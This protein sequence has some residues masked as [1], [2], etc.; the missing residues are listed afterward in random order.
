MTS[1]FLL[2]ALGLLDD[3]LIQDAEASAAP[4]SLP[5]RRWTAWAACLAL[6]LALGYGVTHL[7]MGSGNSGCSSAG[8]VPSASTG[9]SS[10][11]GSPSSSAGAGG[12]QWNGGS[13]GENAASSSPAAGPEVL[14]GFIYTADGEYCLTGE[15]LESLPQGAQPVG[16]LSALSP[17]APLPATDVEDYAGC[18]LWQGPD[19]VVYLQLPQGGYAPA[20]PQP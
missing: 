2:D 14:P 7:G 20:E 18:A 13:G 9:G 4:K 19:G 17:D 3:E 10:A 16:A 5:W 6:V 1:E 11:G 8:G 12:G 15:A